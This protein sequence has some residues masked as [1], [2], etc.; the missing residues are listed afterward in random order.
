MLSRLRAAAGALFGPPPPPTSAYLGDHTA[1]TTLEGRM[2]MFVDTRDNDVAPSLLLRGL[3]EPE[4]TSL[5][6]RLIRPGAT[7]LDIGA[8]Q[9]VYTLLAAR[10]VG[11]TGR[12]HAFE[13]NRRYCELIERSLAVNGFKAQTSIH[14]L[15]LGETAGE[16]ELVFS[17]AWGGGAHLAVEAMAAVPEQERQPCRIAALDEMFA[18]PGFTVDVIKMDIEGAEARALRGMWR[19]LERSPEVRVIFEFAP[20]LLAL[21]G[22]GAAE[23]IHLL[24]ELGFHFWSIGGA[25]RLTAISA[26]SLAEA[27]DGLRNMLA[28]RGTPVPG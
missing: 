11:P 9:G 5:F 7:V 14:N 25:S 13:P 19:L 24:R 23:M 28:A 18:D 8:N 3:W 20:E 26:E 10:A 6:K 17:W 2:M 16:T 1:L 22:V 12:V 15:A 21:H 4:A 27:T